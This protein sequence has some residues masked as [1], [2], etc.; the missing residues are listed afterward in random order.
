MSDL[1][2]LQKLDDLRKNG[3]LTNEEYEAKKSKILNNNVQQEKIKGFKISKPI[4]IIFAFFFI[5]FIARLCSTIISDDKSEVK[6]KSN[7]VNTTVNSELT[8]EEKISKI[9]DILKNIKENKSSYKDNLESINLYTLLIEGYVTTYNQYSNE[10]NPQLDKKLL[11]LKKAIQNFQ[12]SIFPKMRKT[13]FKIVKDKLWRS[14]IEVS[15]LGS[16]NTTLQLTGGTLASNANKEDVMNAMRE[17]T[18]KLRFQKINMKWYEYDDEYT[19][20]DL[21]NK[22]DKE[23]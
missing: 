8:V 23:L 10:K 18:T 14:N 19:Y 12:S 16:N 6:E 9:D 15:L 11:E 5:I 1:E 17:M 4:K 20:Y 13:Y 21:K 2:D 7:F 22:S 3:I